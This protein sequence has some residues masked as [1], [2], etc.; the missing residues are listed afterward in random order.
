MV[1]GC[2]LDSMETSEQN[3]QQSSNQVIQENDNG[4]NSNIPADIELSMTESEQQADNPD[5][6]CTPARPLHA[7]PR[8]LDMLSHSPPLFPSIP[9]HPAENNLF[10]IHAH[11]A[12]PNSLQTQL[13]VRYSHCYY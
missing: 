2:A 13:K 4:L 3:S 8:S 11:L 6:S 9:N 5:F 10:S 12:L 1:Y 7:V